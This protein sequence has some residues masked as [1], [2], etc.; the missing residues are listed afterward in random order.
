VLQ[1]YS[2]IVHEHDLRYVLVAGFIC[3]LAMFT[4]VSLSDQARSRSRRRPAWIALTGFVSGAG[5][6]ATHFIAMLAYRS[7]LAIEYDVRLTLAS[8][9]AAVT[10][11]GLGWAVALLPRRFAPAFGGAIIGAGI[12]AMHSLG[13]AALDIS[14]IEIWQPTMVA[15]SLLLGVALGAAAM[16]VHRFDSPAVPWRSVSLLT[17]AVCAMHFTGMAAI[18][19]YPGAIVRASGAFSDETLTAA[20]AA[21]VFV[22]LAAGFAAVLLDRKLAR[23]ALDEMRRLRTFADAAVEGL[24]ILDG[25][26]IADANASFLDLAGYA[27]LDAAPATISGCFPEIDAALLAGDA[28]RAPIE[29]ALHGV[30]GR[31]TEVELL[32]R[33]IDWHGAALRVLAVRDITERNEASA[34]IAHLAYHDTLTGLPNRAVFNEHLSRTVDRARRGGQPVALLCIDLDGFKA[35]ND[36]YGHPAG[37]ALLKAVAARLRGVIRG[38]DLVARLG[39]DEFAIV[40]AGGIQ[41]DH[42]GL[43]AERVLRQLEE[44]FEIGAEVVRISASIG[45]A[46]LAGGAGD[47]ETLIKNAD[48]ALYRAK[49]DGRGVARFYDA[50]MDEALRQRRQL[51]A[52]LRQAMDQ[53]RLGL[54]YQP[55][56]DIATG[57]VIGFEA[58]AR[59]THPRH[60]AVSPEEFVRLAEEGG[61]IARLGEWVLREACAEAARWDPPLM[62]SVNLSPLQFREPDLAG[63]VE[64]ILAETGLDP[65][66]L[67]LEVT[68]GLLIGDADHALTVLRRLKALGVQISMDDFGIGYSSLSYFRLF[69]FD[70]VKIDQSFV[71]DMGTSVAARAIVRSVIGLAHSLDM[72]VVA[73]G[74]ET[75]EQQEMLRK[76]GCD[77]VQGYLISR[78]QPIGWF[79][80]WA[81]ERIVEEAPRL[82]ACA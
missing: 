75:A 1:V 76:K 68:E 74:V 30:D 28:A 58:L 48:I 4:A 6:W 3:V 77:L 38:V 80:G 72:R 52:D 56:A 57:D 53:G 25:E 63:D 43:L 32:V 44:P 29:T 69:P 21:A 17:L 60:G 54:A 9:V 47:P 8:I 34:R 51:D 11:T 39:G 15:A 24:V 26:R 13:M 79:E 78:P 33:T 73:E 50:A 82:L 65:K 55:V 16:A 37:D 70:K 71:R 36:V 61:Y 59:W 42:A 12:G 49:S 5:I 41:P 64:R 20:I 35:A 45:I 46:T 14:G 19:I 31:T 62:L 23:N 7:E 18:S 81:I 27:D 22:V 66:R 40:Q 67:D 10:V 2:C